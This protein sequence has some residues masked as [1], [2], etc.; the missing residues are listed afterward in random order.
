MLPFVFSDSVT[1]MHTSIQFLSRSCLKSWYVMLPFSKT[2]RRSN[3]RGFPRISDFFYYPPLISSPAVWPGL[4][5]FNSPVYLGGYPLICLTE[6]I[7]LG[8]PAPRRQANATRDI[9]NIQQ[10]QADGAS[11][12]NPGQAHRCSRTEANTQ[13]KQNHTGFSLSG[14][15]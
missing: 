12:D 10:V 14:S 5:G 4:A 11:Q 1:P 2:P 6:Y 7:K 13:G 9:T 15:C 8:S 3:C